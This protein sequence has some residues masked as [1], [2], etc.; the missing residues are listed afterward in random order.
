MRTAAL[1]LATTPGETMTIA[2]AMM[3]MAW[4][5]LA[6]LYRAARAVFK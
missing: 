5:R 6:R 1:N 3:M 4:S 2:L